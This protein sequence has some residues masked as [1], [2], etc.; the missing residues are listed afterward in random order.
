M[1]ML[2][3]TANVQP[4]FPMQELEQ[5]EFAIQASKQL[6]STLE[7][8]QKKLT[9]ELELI[10]RPRTLAI[11]S[12][13]KTVGPGFEYRGVLFRHWSYITI[14]TN[15]LRRLWAEFPEHRDAMAKA[16]GRLGRTRVY[17]AKSFTELF[18]DRPIEWVLRHSSHLVDGWY[19]DTNL[20]NRTQMSRILSAAV[21]AAGLKWGKDVKAYW[22][23]T[24]LG[25]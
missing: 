7:G 11:K 9:E 6:L 21:A 8:R 12:L 17:V 24:P 2:S 14:Y 3:S 18:P 15:L 16:M 19:M 4:Q 13:L 1:Q 23:C 20:T 5:I 25:A 10:T 22:Q